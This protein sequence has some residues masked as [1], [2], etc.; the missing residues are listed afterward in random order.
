VFRCQ[1]GDLDVLLVREE[2]EWEVEE[3]EHWPL[4]GA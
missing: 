3:D 1:P 2:D 4:P